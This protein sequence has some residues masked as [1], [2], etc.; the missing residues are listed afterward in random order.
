MGG[1]IMK[2]VR[3]ILEEKHKNPTTI[4][5]QCSMLDA[6]RLMAETDVGA[7]M[8]VDDG[9]LVGVVS[10][11]DFARKVAESGLTLDAPVKE[12]MTVGVVSVS[13]EHSVEQCMVL[14]LQEH[15]RHLPVLEGETLIGVISVRDVV[16]ATLDEKEYL[17]D[18]LETYI[19]GW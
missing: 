16:W 18:Q 15:F 6:L 11:R 12:V 4:G 5:S 13:P 14:M 3:Q 9:T 7:V 10:E 17:I 2:T 8:V 1:R 19:S